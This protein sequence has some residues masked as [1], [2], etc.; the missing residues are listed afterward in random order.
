MNW[1]DEVV[2]N[3]TG[4]VPVITQDAQSG[5]VLLLA[6]ANREA[7]AETI[8]TGRGVNFSRA[9]GNLWRKGEESGNIQ[10]VSE[11]RLDCD[12]DAVL[13]VVT[14]VGGMACHTGRES[15]FF[16]RLENNVWKVVD[17]VIKDPKELYP[18]GRKTSPFMERI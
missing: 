6:W 17:S 11:V 12:G 18:M 2:F 10:T 9:R 15:C 13:Y 7:L 1:L 5:R 14:Q 4:L 8:S 3:E 16:R